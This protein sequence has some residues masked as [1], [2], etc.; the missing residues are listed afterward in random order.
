M[1][2]IREIIY[3]FCCIF[4]SLNVGALEL[5]DSSERTDC[6]ECH[7]HFKH[8][9]AIVSAGDKCI[10]CHLEFSQSRA[11]Q[12][13]IELKSQANPNGTELH[14]AEA[15]MRYPLYYEESRLGEEPNDM[16]K[17][18]AGEFI[19]G[20]NDRLPDEG[21][22]H[23]R[24]LP[25]YYIDQ[26]EVTNLQYKHFIDATGRRSPKYFKNRTYPIGK[27]DHPVTYVSWYDANEYC[28]WAGK[29]LPTDA[30]WEK[31]A[32]GTKGQYFPWGNE[33]DVDKA[34]TPQRWARIGIEGDTSPVG[35]F[36][37][38]KSP[39]GMYD[40]SGNVWEWTASW[41]EPYPGNTHP[42]ENYGQQ[43]KTLK[44]GSWWD[45]SFYK[46]GISAP[47]YNRSFFLRSTKNNSFGFRCASDKP[48]VRGGAAGKTKGK[49]NEKNT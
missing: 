16:V 10:S 31:A 4:L 44:G 12:Q 17:I 29:R 14:L 32:R 37:K 3:L 47:L 26:Y 45:C 19:M 23:K 22:Q 30:E 9:H 8:K 25:V 41:Y 38:G 40:A 7:K 36:E 33:F 2:S 5:S 11:H 28:H 43:Y 15:G 48:V 20:T 49:K 42:T 18:P 13:K 24:S 35:S 1:F 27:T 39:Y 46:C 34:N 21:P 6:S